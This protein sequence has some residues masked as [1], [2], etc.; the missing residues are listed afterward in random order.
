MA[1]KLF[2]LA[3][4]FFPSTRAFL[5]NKFVPKSTIADCRRI[6]SALYSSAKSNTNPYDM[7]LKPL[8]MVVELEIKEEFV[9]EFLKV[10]E[11]DAIGSCNNENGGCL[12]FD[13]LKKK[14]SSNRFTL[15]EVYTNADALAF[16]KTTP[17][18]KLWTDFKA[19]GAV[20]SQTVEQSNIAFFGKP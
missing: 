12:R 2:I 6:S 14:S 4:L 3:S 13:V 19:T 17:H 8:A 18:Y 20:L 5:L 10:I 7:S 15:Y 11:A 9:D 16:H 1:S